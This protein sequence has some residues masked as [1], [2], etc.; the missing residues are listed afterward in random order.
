MEYNFLPYSYRERRNKKKTYI[1]NIVIIILIIIASILIYRIIN[2]YSETKKLKESIKEINYSKMSSKIITSTD[3]NSD[4]FKNTKDFFQYAGERFKIENLIVEGKI[5]NANIVLSTKDDY[6]EAVRY[7]ENNSY[8]NII[9]L[10]SIEKEAEDIFK[11]QVSM[12]VK[13]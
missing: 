7:I 6:E 2:L 5:I 12:E 13:K 4:I 9:K 1:L 3:N 11:F 10:S 8:W